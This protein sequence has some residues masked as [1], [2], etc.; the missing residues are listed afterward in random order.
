MS[1][2]QWES[3]VVEKPFCQQLA[4]MGWQW[5]EG[6]PDLPETT[7]RTNSRD[8]RWPETVGQGVGVG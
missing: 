4:A 6:D 5:I 1:K 7:E 8:V 2:V 3:E